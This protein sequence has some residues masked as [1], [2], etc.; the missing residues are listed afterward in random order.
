MGEETGDSQATVENHAKS[1]GRKVEAQ[2]LGFD[3]SQLE[4]I[5]QIGIRV[6][7]LNLFRGNFKSL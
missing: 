3:L 5:S 1:L 2:S 7:Y 4:L 6:F